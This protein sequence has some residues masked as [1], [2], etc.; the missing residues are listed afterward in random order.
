[1][2]KP[3]TAAYVGELVREHRTKAV[4]FPPSRIVRQKDARTTDAPCQWHRGTRAV[5]QGGNARHAKR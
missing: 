4:L 1:M 5:E 3:I 2:H